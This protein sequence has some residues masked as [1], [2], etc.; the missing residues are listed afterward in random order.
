MRFPVCPSAS[1]RSMKTSPRRKLPVERKATRL[2]EGYRRLATQQA[3]FVSAIRRGTSA[4]SIGIIAVNVLV[5]LRMPP[6][7]T[8]ET[9]PFD[10]R[11]LHRELGG[12]GESGRAHGE[13]AGLP[14]RVRD[15]EGAVTAF[16]APPDTTMDEGAFLE[17]S[18]R[19]DCATS[20][21]WEAVAGPTPPQMR[22][23]A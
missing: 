23:T 9:F 19:A 10:G 8:W 12:R 7:E 6:V 18:A 21:G 17:L 1:Q 11:A 2:R 20:Y 22:S 5:F 14:G 3:R 4:V 16:A 15:R 13:A